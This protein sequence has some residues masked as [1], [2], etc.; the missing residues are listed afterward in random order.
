MSSCGAWCCFDEFSR[1]SQGVLSAAA[2][3]LQA[4]L[5]AIRAGQDTVTLDGTQL[6]CSAD[7]HVFVT[8]LP[9][10]VY[11]GRCSLPDNIKVRGKDSDK[12]RWTSWS[13]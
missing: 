13:C 11:R 12:T 4:V 2:H 8:S 7:C 3:Y 9:P 5:R 10:D 1:L 6:R